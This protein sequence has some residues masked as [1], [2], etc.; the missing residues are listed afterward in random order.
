[1]YTGT[2]KISNKIVFSIIFI[3]AVF[4]APSLASNP[5]GPFPR[6]FYVSRTGDN[7][8]GLSWQTAFNEMDQIQWER[9]D[10]V[11]G[12]RVVI[13]GGSSHMVYRTQLNIQ[14]RV[15]F[16]PSPLRV[17]LSNEVGRNGR[18]I[19]YGARRKQS[20]V[21][22]NGPHILLDGTKKRGIMVCGWGGDGIEMPE[23]TGQDSIVR[24]LD[25]CYNRGAGIHVRS[26]QYSFVRRNIVHDNRVNIL[27]DPNSTIA[28]FI[29]S[30][31]VYNSSYKYNTD[32][33]VMGNGK[34]IP[35]THV[36]NCV[37]GPG[38][39]RGFHSNG[40]ESYG[41]FVKNCLFINATKSN[42][43]TR[44][45]LFVDKC[46]SFMTKSNPW[47]RSHDTI[48]IDSGQSPSRLERVTSSIFYGGN[49]R[50]SPEVRYTAQENIPYRTTGN[51]TFLSA[52]QQDPQF[53]ANLKRIRSRASIRFLTSID[54]SLEPASPA[55]GKGSSITSVKQFLDSF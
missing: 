13:D 9:I 31:W 26:R 49:V 52:S 46:T 37:I 55:N 21:V 54:F 4:A 45:G 20:G 5:N 42:I 12:D 40:S 36:Q 24:Y 50:V 33:I 53:V 48:R 8:D 10:V 29:D 27:V 14:S 22:I 17:S 35:L 19:I 18:A 39:R 38:L 1:M 43:S 32:G 51:T 47:R 16:Q 7:S 6:T 41:N 28:G 11:R 2:T 30:C 23:G 44:I 34:T 25:V 3:I 15:N